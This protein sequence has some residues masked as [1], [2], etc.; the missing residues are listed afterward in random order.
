LSPAPFVFLTS[1]MEAAEEEAGAVIANQSVYINEEYFFKLLQDPAE[2][3]S[4]K[5]REKFASRGGKGKF[6]VARKLYF[7]DKM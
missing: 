7:D 1:T 2:D 3:L 4:E 6:T 5:E